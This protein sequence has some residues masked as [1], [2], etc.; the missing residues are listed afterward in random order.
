MNIPLVKVPSYTMKLLDREIKYRPF[1]VKEQKILLLANESED[2]ELILQTVGDI[3]R[4]C[5]F[6]AIDIESAP[7]FEVQ[8]A[9][10]MIRGKSVGEVMEFYSVCGACD[11]RIPTS[12][13]VNDFSLKTTPGHTNK[14]I[15]DNDFSVTM[16]YPTFKHFAMLFGEESEDAVYQVIAECIHE[17][18]TNDEVFIN[19]NETK[20]E[21]R[22]FLDNLTVQQLEK[23]EN[24]FITMPLLQH[25][26]EFICPKCQK[27]NILMVD[28]ISNFFE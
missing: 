7:M 12:L 10:L 28:G 27:E 21:I 24:F 20:K 25:R 2:K 4:E 1:L 26:I 18:F 13:S 8:Q 14:I 16:R 17:V 6:G 15:L 3:V 19:T 11:H 9:F 5:T 23:L 22:E